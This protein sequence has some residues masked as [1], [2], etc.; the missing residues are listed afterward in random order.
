MGSLEVAFAVVV[1]VLAAVCVILALVVAA[2]W[3]LVQIG[4]LRAQFHRPDPMFWRDRGATAPTIPPAEREPI[5][6]GARRI[7][8]GESLRRVALDKGRAS[9]GGRRKWS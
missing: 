3:L 8:A 5:R 4:R 9:H 2:Y 6:D 7:L 1:T